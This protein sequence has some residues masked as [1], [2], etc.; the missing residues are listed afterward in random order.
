MSE[1]KLVPK[2]RFNGFD[3]GWQDTT[4]ND[5]ATFTKG[6][7][8]SKNDISDEGI[9][10]VRYGELYT[11]YGE[12]IYD[13]DSKTNLNK[14]E[15][16]LS[17]KNDILIPC[18]GETAIDLATASCIQK[19]NVAIGG[20]IT[21]IQTNQYAPFITYYLNQ[22]KNEIA[23]FAQGVSI[24][25][26]YSKDFKALKMK[27]PSINEQKKIISLLEI[28][29]N[30]EQL[31]KQK[32]QYYQN[33]KKY[34]MQQI[35]AQKLRFNFDEEWVEIKLRDIGTFYRGHSYNSGNVVD[36]G[37]LVLRSNNIQDNALDFS[38]SE[39]QF[40]NKDCKKEL[41][42]Q[43]NDIVI[44]MSNGTRSLVGKSAQYLGNYNKKLTVGAFCSIFRT[45]NILAKYLFQTEL[46]RKNLYLILAGTNINN[47]KNSDLEKFKFK[48]PNNKTETKKIHDLFSSVD[49]N[50][51]NIKNQLNE[52]KL[53]K[54][55]LLQQMFV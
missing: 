54:K 7:D 41:E 3:D 25:H 8:I 46:Y 15:L 18:S 1:E 43:K 5:I 22:K 28:I 6:K 2:L 36:N 14:N 27:I 51:E 30:K 55:S 34:L 29:T 48:I 23:R 47:L 38:D 13:I 21:I 12:L 20:D 24:V 9:E 26:L 37:L 44:C 39:L 17:N 49:M 50:I 35:F 16:I 53:F 42:L 31:L 19:E 33:F 10:C 11:K 45:N 4:L 32:Y 52:I 40:V